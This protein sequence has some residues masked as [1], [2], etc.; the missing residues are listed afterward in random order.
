MQSTKSLPPCPKY[1][2]E[3][4]LQNAWR[5]LTGQGDAADDP[6]PEKKSGK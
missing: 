1:D 3:T 5:A 4:H 2:K 6:Y